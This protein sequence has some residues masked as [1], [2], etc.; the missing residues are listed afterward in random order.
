VSVG[1]A[2]GQTLTQLLRRNGALN[3]TSYCAPPPFKKNNKCRYTFE[4]GTWRSTA[5]GKTYLVSMVPFFGRGGPNGN[6]DMEHWLT[7][8]LAVAPGAPNTQGLELSSSALRAFLDS[9]WGEWRTPTLR[10]LETHPAYVE[11]FND[12]QEQQRQYWDEDPYGEFDDIFCKLEGTLHLATNSDGN[13]WWT[14]LVRAL[15][16]KAGGTVDEWVTRI[17]CAARMRP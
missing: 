5:T 8:L 7:H 4:V 13:L 17:G 6:A 16:D 11:L 9:P 1:K 10:F 2:A 12:I 15:R 14:A 3:M